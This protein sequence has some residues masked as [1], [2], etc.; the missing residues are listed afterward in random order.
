MNRKIIKIFLKKE[1]LAL[2]LML[3]LAAFLRLQNVDHDFGF[4]G[5][6]GRDLLVVRDWLNGGP[7]PLVGPST[8][9]GDFH[10]GPFFFYLLAPFVALFDF[11]AIAPVHLMFLAGMLTILISFFLVKK[12][13]DSLTALLV[14]FLIAT[15]PIAV[16]L[17]RGSWN[18]NIEPVFVVLLL[19]SLFSLIK[20]GRLIFAFVTFLILGIGIQLHYTFAANI[21]SSTL[22]LLI[23]RPKIFKDYRFYLISA[24]GFLLPLSTFFYGQFLN[25]FQDLK[26]FKFAA[27]TPDNPYEKFGLA[28]LLRRLVYPFRVYLPFDDFPLIKPFAYLI[29][30]LI[31]AGSVAIAFTKSKLSFITRVLVIFYLSDALISMAARINYYEHYYEEFAILTLFLSGLSI[32]YLFKLKKLIVLAIAGFLLLAVWQLKEIP[33]IYQISRTPQVAYQISDVV[34]SDARLNHKNNFGVFVVSPVTLHQGF[35][36][37]YLIE[38]QGFKTYS[39][40]LIGQTDYLIVEEADDQT[41]QLDLLNGDLKMR[42]LKKLYFNDESQQIKSAEIYRRI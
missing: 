36:H 2:V 28:T 29:Y 15:S 9:V 8:S 32:S 11:S 6:Q 33:Q 22:I 21:I 42:L 39:P 1:T 14:S 20:T 16:F 30:S 27:T 13:T 18:P 23:F 40:E 41:T 37:R 25:H 24:A 38:T 10:T 19:L 7:L 35:E 3:A 4:F 31:L 26:I 12:Q 17:S 5:D 34:S